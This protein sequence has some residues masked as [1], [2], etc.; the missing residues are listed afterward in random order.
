MMEGTKTLPFGAVWDYHCEREGVPQDNA[1]LALVEA[2]ERE[3][4][5]ARR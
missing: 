3:V 4:L 1:W 2:Y 5:E